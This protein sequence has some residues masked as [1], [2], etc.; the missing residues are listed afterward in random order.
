MPN[1]TMMCKGTNCP[2][3]DNCYRYLADPNEIDQI[4]FENVP[5]NDRTKECSHFW[6]ASKCP[7][8][9]QMNGVHKMDCESNR[10]QINIS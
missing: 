8:C 3:A 7:Y 2:L 6:D 10:I 5:Y 1:V 9:N 4:Y